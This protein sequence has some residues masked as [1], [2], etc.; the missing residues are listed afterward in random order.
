MKMISALASILAA[1][2]AGTSCENKE[3]HSSDQEDLSFEVSTES[4]TK[5]SVADD[6]VLWEEGD[7]IAVFDGTFTGIYKAET[8]GATAKF[9]YGSESTLKKSGSYEAFFPAS[10]KKGTMS[11]PATVSYMDGGRTDMPMYARSDNEKLR[12]SNLC[13]LFELA[14]ASSAEDLNIKNVTISANE[15]LCGKFS[16]EAAGN[17]WKA[18]LGTDGS[19]TLTMDC[20]KNGLMCGK[21]A[22]ILRFALCEGT[23]T[24]VSVTIMTDDGSTYKYS[25]SD[26]VMIG[27]NRV[28]R[29]SVDMAALT[30][31]PR[32]LRILAIGNSFSRD[33]VEQYLWE[34]FH[35]AGKDVVIGNM[36]IGGCSLSRHWNEASQNLKNYEYRKIVD[37][38]RTNTTGTSLAEALKD[39]YWDYISF[40]QGSGDY[41]FI[42]T[43]EPYLTDLISYCRK[44]SAKRNFKIIYHVTWAAAA[45]STNSNFINKYHSNQMEMYT[46]TNDVVKELNKDGRFDLVVNSCDAIQNG[47]SSYIGDNFNTTDGWHLNDYG[48]FTAA[49]T[50]YEAISGNDAT[51]NAYYPSAKMDNVKAEIFKTAAHEAVLHPYTITDLSYFVDPDPH[52][53]TDNVLASWLFDKNVIAA[54]GRLATWLT[55]GATI[56]DTVNNNAAGESGYMLSNNGGDGKLSYVQVD[57]TAFTAADQAAGRK[58]M[59]GTP[60]GQPVIF[61]ALPGDYWLFE[62]GIGREFAAGTQLKMK[63]TVHPDKYGPMYW[64]VE[65]LD[66]NEW[67]AGLQT[68]TES[69]SFTDSDTSKAVS[70]TLTYNVKCTASTKTDIALDV[71]LTTATTGFKV[72]LVC[73]S[74]YQV[75][76]KWWS[77]P[78]QASAFRIAGTVSDN[79]LPVMTLEK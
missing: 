42:N 14:L 25:P 41:G 65:Y 35:E 20:G 50:W 52:P 26:A 49:C 32:P 29:L 34:L 44:N 16:V 45:F 54:D 69:F 47:R 66:G 39:E 28:S 21:D 76:G 18:V 12:M 31:E 40:Q 27:R 5:A 6:A 58:L 78:R 23:Y 72:R 43:F 51:K 10:L 71:T 56:S 62:G 48:K 67:K 55:E 75:N 37:G 68:S 7:E 63:F 38:V 2:I 11:L 70:E 60:G 30:M 53:D 61:G 33:A 1:A 46:M 77:H 22:A 74:T 36:Y 73:C 17:A 4:L 8:G 9:S 24:G 19:K 57:K 15:G 79:N 59:T 13:G 64:R 3:P